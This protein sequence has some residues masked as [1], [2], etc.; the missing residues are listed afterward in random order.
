MK[1]E[2]RRIAGHTR[3]ESE[4]YGDYERVC[5]VE[6]SPGQI[7]RI[8]VRA[9]PTVRVPMGRCRNGRQ[10]RRLDAQSKE[11]STTAVVGAN[12]GAKLDHGSGMTSAPLDELTA[13]ELAKVEPADGT[14]HT[15]LPR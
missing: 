12:G 15:R 11:K 3:I 1:D 5:G 7:E 4:D 9:Q 8:D 13:A 14:I 2:G 6:P 10:A